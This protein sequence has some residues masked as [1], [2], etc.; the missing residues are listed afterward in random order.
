MAGEPQYPCPTCKGWGT[1]ED[2]CECCGNI[3]DVECEDCNGTGWDDD[4]VDTAFYAEACAAF[5]R[6]HKATCEWTN[7][8]DS[9]KSIGRREYDGPARL[10]VADFFRKED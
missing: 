6:L 4:Y 1:Y 9:Y 10:P 5:Q 8:E 7:P 3:D 2:E